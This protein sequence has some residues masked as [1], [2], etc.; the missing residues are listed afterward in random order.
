MQ[1]RFDIENDVSILKDKKFNYDYYLD[2][3]LEVFIKDN[4]NELSLFSTTMHSTIIIELSELLTELHQ[5]GKKQTLD[6][7][8]NANTYTLEKVG[9]NIIVTNF[10]KLSNK[11]EW[12]HSFELVEFTN[13]YIKEMKKYL[14][15]MVN[16]EANITN[17]QNYILLRERLSMLEKSVQPK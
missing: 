7:F 3:F 8:G 14:N 2:S 9:N 10:D 13:A 1:L 4:N 5:T 11:E 15:A 6:P 16:V 12:K 17:N